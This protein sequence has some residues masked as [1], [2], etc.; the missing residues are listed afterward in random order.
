LSVAVFVLAVAVAGAAIAIL[1]SGRGS[2]SNI[3]VANV[4]DTSTATPTTSAPAQETVQSTTSTAS[5]NSDT[6]QLPDE[7]TQQ[8]QPEIQQMLLEWH[9]DVVHGNYHA[10]W[11]LLSARKRNQDEREEGYGLWV[12]D[13]STL[14][15]YLD[16]S[17]LR[18]SVEST[19][20]ESGV[21]QVDVTGMGWDKPG[22]PCDEW[23]GITWVKYEAGAWKYD[24]GYS[25]TPQRER[26]W[27]PRFS[28]LLGGR[29]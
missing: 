5:V 21:A 9:E 24:P 29:C 6:G 18:I 7:S 10:A 2:T 8:M 25:T 20:P 3:R 14:R 28:E 26:E 4:T 16:P 13:Q 15:P 22:A 23:S 27:K 17:N 12:K 19:E 1:L 11:L